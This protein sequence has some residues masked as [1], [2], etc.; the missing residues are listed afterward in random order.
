MK[1]SGQVKL[2]RDVDRSVIRRKTE[3]IL[4]AGATVLIGPRG[5]LDQV[6][7]VE[8]GLDRVVVQESGIERDDTVLGSIT[9]QEHAF[10]GANN[11]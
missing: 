5:V 6:G 7:L 8:P 11:R 2:W 9:E 10:A 4:L 1:N 3:R